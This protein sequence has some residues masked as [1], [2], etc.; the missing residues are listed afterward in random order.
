MQQSPSKESHIIT[1]I[2]D[3][4]PSKNTKT[5]ILSIDDL[6]SKINDETV[7]KHIQQLNSNAT[8]SYLSSLHNQLHELRDENEELKLNF[9]QVSELLEETKEK[10]EQNEKCYKE[11]IELLMKER[12]RFVKQSTI[13]RE[14]L[15]KLLSNCKEENEHLNN[16]LKEIN[17][18]NE[19]LRKDNF[20]LNLLIIEQ[21]KIEYE[22]NLLK[23]QIKQGL[24][25]NGMDNNSNCLNNIQKKNTNNIGLKK[26]GNIN[27]TQKDNNKNLYTNNIGKSKTPPKIKNKN[28]Q[29]TPIKNKEPK[30][31]VNNRYNNIKD[32]HETINNKVKEQK[33]IPHS[34]TFNFTPLSYQKYESSPLLSSRNGRNDCE[35]SFS[36]DLSKN[37][38]TIITHNPNNDNLNISFAPSFGIPQGNEE[39]TQSEIKSSLQETLSKAYNEYMEKLHV[40]LI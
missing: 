22:N 2:T 31:E 20:K 33:L 34:Y 35:Y 25:Y 14:T 10:A 36:T 3:I 29:V 27:I 6:S 13:E 7:S 32:S 28:K 21:S 30:K 11:K 4:S 23:E 16:R 5:N 39:L 8:T 26:K 19:K 18:E 24:Q 9:V 15:E 1:T 38:N 17:K 12:D 40:F 37:T